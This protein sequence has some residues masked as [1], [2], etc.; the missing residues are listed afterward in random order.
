ME[1]KLY[2]LVE[3]Y[4][5][6]CMRDSAHDREHI[7]RV[8]YAAVDIASYEKDVNLDIL[9]IAA[10][11]HDIGRI[12]QYEDSNVCHATAGGEMAYDFLI[13]NGLK[14]QDAIHVKECI[15]SHRFRTDD[16]P[17][18]IEAKILFDAD[19]L[20]ATGVLGIA[21]T[22]LY[23]GV[24]SKPLYSVDEDGKVLDGTDEET[25]SFF[26]EYHFKLR[27]LYDRFY[28]KRAEDLAHERLE[29]FKSFYKSML[30]EV[31]SNYENGIAKLNEQIK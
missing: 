14:E 17:R 12:K 7:Y 30:W 4:M 18:T 19:K 27:K 6:E 5:K 21:R 15:Q 3:N 16:I 22:L 2:E 20:D 1:K 10:L 9:I 11:L 23:C 28:T 29:E 8:L 25:G 13:S 24:V 31:T 26:N